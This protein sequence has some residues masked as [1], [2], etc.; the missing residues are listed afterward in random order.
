[1]RLVQ[2][3]RLVSPLLAVALVRPVVVVL[4]YFSLSSIFLHS[5]SLPHRRIVW[6]N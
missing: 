4:A 1:V 6:S 5:Q 2:Q 3:G